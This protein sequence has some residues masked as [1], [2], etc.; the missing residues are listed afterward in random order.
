MY[1]RGFTINARS[2]VASGWQ[3]RQ[4]K[5]MSNDSRSPSDPAPDPQLMKRFERVIGSWAEATTA[6][7]AEVAQA[8]AMQALAMCA[9]QELKNPSPDV[10]LMNEADELESK[11]DW[12]AAEAM[13]RKILAIKESSGNFGVI[14]KAQMDL[15]NFL[16]LVGKLDEAWRVGCVATVSARHANISVLLAMALVSEAFCALEG[17]CSTEALAAASE[18]VQVIEPGK[19]YDMMRAKALAVRAKCLLA[20]GDPIGAE[21]DLDA[22]WELLKADSFFCV[23]P[24]PIFTLA[25]WWEAKSQLEEQRG[26][27]KGALEAMTNALNY[28]RHGESPHALLALSHALKKLGEISSTTQD[29]EGEERFLSETKSI[30][31]NLHLPAGN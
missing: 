22:S 5:C 9:E 15:C 1:A 21:R 6:G 11:R 18:A 25:N 8:A 30:L 14:S 28:R 4:D 10:L 3:P 2:A 16:R 29:H 24:G 26:N 27:I 13:R 12:S 31:E 19:L 17:G 20:C 23:M 7:N